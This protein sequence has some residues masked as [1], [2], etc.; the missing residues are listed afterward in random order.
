M[1][2]QAALIL[3]LVAATGYGF[4]EIRR[5]DTPAGR[6]TVSRK[7]RGLRAWGLFFLEA[8]LGLWLGGT[9]LPTPHK[10]DKQAAIIFI[11]YWAITV[12]AAVPL[13]PLAFLDA[14]ENQRWIAEERKKLIQETLGPHV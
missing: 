8:S 10:G 1:I 6:G 4:W 11:K 13:M 12:L 9:Y 2:L 7:Q 14:R 5:W 3:G